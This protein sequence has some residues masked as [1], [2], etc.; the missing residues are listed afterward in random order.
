MKKWK[1]QM[2]EA[3]DI[4][5]KNTKK[6]AERNKRNYDNKMRSSVLYEGD[7]VLVR[8]LTP[9]GGT[10]KLRNHWEDCIYKV[11]RQVGEDMPIYEVLPEQGKGRTSRVL[12]RN[13]LLPCNNLLLTP[14]KRKK[15]TTTPASGDGTVADQ[16]D[17]DSDDN[18]YRY[19]CVRTNQSSGVVQPVDLV[20]QSL[21]DVEHQ[22]QGLPRQ[23]ENQDTGNMLN[24]GMTPDQ[25]MRVEDV[26]VNARRSPVRPSSLPSGDTEAAQHHQR[27]VR[28]RRPPRVFTYDR[29]AH[30]AC[31]TT[32]PPG[33]PSN[34]VYWYPPVPLPYGTVPTAGVWLP[35]TPHSWTL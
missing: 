5:T 35:D 27:P 17:E 21:N 32:G 18:G 14:T 10:G 11:I 26:P 25:E 2:Q 8:N 33:P 1:A 30:P 13:L 12:H 34:F 22:L 23:Q 6:S 15:K 7:R 24:E 3:Y 16:A 20:E 19:H 4:T 31:C 29:L 9:R 28:E